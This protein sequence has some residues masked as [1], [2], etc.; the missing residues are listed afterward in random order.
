MVTVQVEMWMKETTNKVQTIPKCFVPQKLPR[1]ELRN[2]EVCLTTMSC[3]N[4][5]LNVS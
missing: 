3:V 5:N 1:F 2:Q 4:P